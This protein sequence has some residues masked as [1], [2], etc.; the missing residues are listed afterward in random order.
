MIKWILTIV[1]LISSAIL[2]YMYV[3][4]EQI[5]STPEIIPIPTTNTVRI[6]DAY[7]DGVHRFT[8]QVRLGHS[9]YSLDTAVHADP[10]DPNVV[11]ITLTSKDKM[12]DQKLC[13][14]IPTAYPFEE[15]FEGPSTMTARLVL[16]EKELPV[17]LIKTAWQSPG[18]DVTNLIEKAP[19]K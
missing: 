9:C 6:V 19:T 12:L 3:E 1:I 16:D 14:Q 15:V 18:G 5:S 8:G 11:I 4:L 7:S 2:G 10:K 13:A 17:R